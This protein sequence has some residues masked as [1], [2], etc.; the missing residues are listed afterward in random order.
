MTRSDTSGGIERGAWPIFESCRSEA[1]KLRTKDG[2]WNAGRRNDGSVMALL[3]QAPLRRLHNLC[4]RSNMSGA[5]IYYGRSNKLVSGVEEMS[6][7]RS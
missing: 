7:I 1:E 5:S 2:D 6:S 4:D 3:M